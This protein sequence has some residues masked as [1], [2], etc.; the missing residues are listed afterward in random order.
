M[1]EQVYSD[2]PVI[3]H[4]ITVKYEDQSRLSETLDEVANEFDIERDG[5]GPMIAITTNDVSWDSPKSIRLNREQLWKIVL[6][7]EDEFQ[8]RAND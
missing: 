7:V 5:H 4:S 8:Q 6:A 3:G 2:E 1:T